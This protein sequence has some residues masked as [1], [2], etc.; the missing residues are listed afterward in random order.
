[1]A[2][3]ERDDEILSELRRLAAE[4]DP[5]PW[6]VTSYAKAALGWRRLEADLAELRSDSALRLTPAFARS[7]E[8]PARS[9]T[10]RAD[11]LDIDLSIQDDDGRLV[12]MGQLTPPGPA[13]IEVQRD[14]SSVAATADA[15]SLG[16]FRIELAE[17]GRVRLLVLRDAPIRP[18]ETSWIGI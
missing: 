14:D 5:V 11:G 1:M 18:V 17:G 13:R 12:L 4:V 16:R 8:A 15:D 2:D 9:V 7:G 6:E 3:H 10:F